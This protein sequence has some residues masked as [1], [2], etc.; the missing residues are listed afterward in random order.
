MRNILNAF[1]LKL[2]VGAA[3]RLAYYK[4]SFQTCWWFFIGKDNFEMEE[5]RLTSSC[6]HLQSPFQGFHDV[7]LMEV[8]GDEIAETVEAQFD[9]LPQK[10][11]PQ[12]RGDSLQEWVPLSGIVARGRTPVI[13]I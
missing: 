10:R 7:E 9:R 5:P 11:K 13:N 12:S 6:V 4:V 8:T 2:V 1:I 3:L